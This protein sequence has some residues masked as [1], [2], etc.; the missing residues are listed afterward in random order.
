MIP[1]KK[2]SGSWRKPFS[3]PRRLEEV[4][5]RRQSW[6]SHFLLLF[7]TQ[8]QKVFG[9]DAVVQPPKEGGHH[10]QGLSQLCWGVG[11]MG[12][13]PERGRLASSW[14]TH[15]VGLD[16]S[17]LV[18]SISTHLQLHGTAR[19]APACA[20]LGTLGIIL[21]MHTQGLR[22]NPAAMGKISQDKSRGRPAM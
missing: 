9:G 5:G 21:P 19:A 10:S 18:Q 1:L 13:E 17:T 15:Q 8:E 3:T 6:T 11:C 16:Q 14:E 4:Q 7:S 20:E 2:S 12:Q 22:Q